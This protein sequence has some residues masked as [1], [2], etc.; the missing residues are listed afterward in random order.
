MGDKLQSLIEAADNVIE[1][2]D[3]LGEYTEVPTGLIHAI[4]DLHLALSEYTNHDNQ[5]PWRPIETIPKDGTEVIA[6]RSNGWITK[7]V[8]Y[9]NPF[10][11]KDTVIEN[12]SGKWWSVTHWM[13]LPPN[14]K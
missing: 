8:W 3:K 5:S 9:D 10:G 12:A 2:S 1:E 7:A 14:P 11:R 6:I 4:D 13:P